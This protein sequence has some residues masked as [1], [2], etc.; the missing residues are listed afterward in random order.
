MAA[1]IKGQKTFVETAVN[2]FHTPWGPQH[3][4]FVVIPSYTEIKIKIH[5]KSENLHVKFRL[6]HVIGPVIIMFVMFRL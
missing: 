2:S 4:V 6:L 1:M 3:F 5:S